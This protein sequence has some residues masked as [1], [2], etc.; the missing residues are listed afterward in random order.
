MDRNLVGR[1]REVIVLPLLAESGETFQLSSTPVWVRP[2]AI[3]L[4][5]APQ[6]F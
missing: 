4:T 6:T 1:I 3:A 5:V 2:I